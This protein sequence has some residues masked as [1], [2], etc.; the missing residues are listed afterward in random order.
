MSHSSPSLLLR[1]LHCSLPVIA[2]IYRDAAGVGTGVLGKDQGASS[3]LFPPLRV[4]TTEDGEAVTDFF[5]RELGM[6]ASALRRWR[7][8]LT[9]A[10]RR[11]WWGGEHC[12]PQRGATPAPPTNM[13]DV[14]FVRSA[15]EDLKA[16]VSPFLTL[17]T[18]RRR[19]GECGSSFLATR[20]IPPGVYLLSLPV[21]AIM[22]A[23]PP[24]ASDPIT[25][26]FM[27][28]EDLVG[29]LV[30]AGDEVTG[31]DWRPSHAGY[32]NYLKKSVIPSNNLPFL[33]R[34]EITQILKMGKAT[35]SLGETEAS[36]KQSSKSPALELWEYFHDEMQGLPLSAYLRQRLSKE[37]Y[38]WWVSLVLSR[39]AGA[40]TLIPLVDKLNHDPEPN[41]YYTMATEDSFCGIDVFDN[42]L[43]GVPSDLLYEPFLHTF[44]IREIQEGEELTLCYASPTIHLNPH[45][46]R[47]GDGGGGMSVASPEGRTAWQ[48]QWGFIPKGDSPYSSTDLKE[49]AAIVAERRVNLRHQHFPSSAFEV[50]AGKTRH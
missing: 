44:S 20:R 16:V 10:V 7:S 1:N 49:V 48:L 14:L 8:G 37:E 33:E 25:S 6:G 9:E 36:F 19:S 31:K 32:V 18:L 11:R 27:Y 15:I 21:E 13:H 17:A 29:Q 41:C 22:F 42:L 23:Q 35:T 5:C 34:E 3:H 38:A 24:P 43:A 26:F 47:S 39:R 46:S 45:S 28:V 50:N 2:Q 40:A 30:V 12:L 4:F